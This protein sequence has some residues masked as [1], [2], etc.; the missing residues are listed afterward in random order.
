MP[1]NETR[2]LLLGDSLSDAYNIPVDQSWPVLF[3][4]QLQK[5]EPDTTLV[6]ASISGETTSGGLERL[7]ELLERHQPTHLIIELGG[8]DGLRGLS[9]N[10]AQS[11]LQAM[12]D[13]ALEREIQV[14]LIG[15]RLPPN[16][17]PA[18]NRLFQE[19]YAALVE[20][21][22]VEYLPR[23]LDGIA[24]DQP[25][26]MQEDGIHPTASAQPLLAD[27]VLAVFRRAWLQSE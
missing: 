15:V 19:M 11:N 24:A 26:L 14:L 25:S 9:F 17:G 3:Q 18:Y 6:N 5:I 13:L 1:Q 21:N 27:K 22:P 20:R 12:I 8:N 23:F 2:I 10:Q 7:P 4:R 16:M